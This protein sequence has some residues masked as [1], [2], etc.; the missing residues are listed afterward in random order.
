VASGS[1]GLHGYVR[2]NP[3]FQANDWVAAYAQAFL[4]APTARDGNLLL[5]A[6]DAHQLWVNGELVSTR[7]GRNIS[8]ADDLDVPV[9]LEAGWNRVLIKIANLDGGWAFH[10]RAADP[11][12]ELRWATTA[13]GL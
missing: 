3:H 5:G 2:L 8:V 10:L 12:G 1:R 13:P 6:D 4:F 9:R 11:V 7:Q